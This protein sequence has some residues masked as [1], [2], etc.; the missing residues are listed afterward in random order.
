MTSLMK[1]M[2]VRTFGGPE[3]FERAEIAKPVAKV[4]EVLVKVAASSV[5]TVDC[6]IRK[7]GPELPLSPEPPAV[8]GM[9]FAGTVEAVGDGVES[10]K[11]GDEVYG[12][13]GGLAQLPGS[14]AEYMAADAKLIAKKPANLSM[15]QAAALPLVG[16]T[17]YEGLKRAGISQGQKVLVHGG[18]GGVG[19]V[20]V[21]LA[22]YWGADVYAT[23]GGAAQLELIEKTLKATGINYKTDAVAD[24]VQKH[25]DGAGFDVI[26][27]S[28]GGANL[29]K[30]FEAAKLNGQIATTVSLLE[31]DLTPAHFKG[32]SIHVV[33]MLIP[34]LYNVNRDEHGAIL[35]DIANI[36]ELG[37]L[38]PVL[39]E[40]TFKLDDVAQAHAR[41]ESG[42]AMGKVVVETDG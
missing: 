27:D 40:P 17:A 33:F 2:M 1:A 21:Q 8:L 18:S 36:A 32:L 20:A 3:V 15:K 12:C 37:L 39:D 35:A 26:F 10:F 30:S 11:A 5:N 41:L 19:H 38:T 24:Y 6:M 7:M 13:A 31:L 42:K 28:V 9:D 22:K 14:L 16:I 23:A 25:T 34:M 29:L 4:G